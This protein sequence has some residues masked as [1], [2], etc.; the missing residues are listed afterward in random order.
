MQFIRENFSAV[1]GFGMAATLV[2]LVP[3][4][5]L[6]VLPFGVAGAARLVVARSGPGR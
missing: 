6:L 4:V 2:L 3:G 5:G 1:V